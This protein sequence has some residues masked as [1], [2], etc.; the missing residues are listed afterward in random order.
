MRLNPLQNLTRNFLVSLIKETQTIS[1][2]E[3]IIR[4]L[5][6]VQACS[7]LNTYWLQERDKKRHAGKGSHRN[8]FRLSGH[9]I[10]QGQIK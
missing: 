5:P 2:L 6:F 8:L 1:L 4:S 9:V 10:L 3:M 7:Q